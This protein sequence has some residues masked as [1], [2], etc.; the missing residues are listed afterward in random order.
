METNNPIFLE[1]THITWD[2]PKCNKKDLPEELELQWNSSNWTN[3]EV[4]QWLSEYFNVKV[5]SLNVKKLA[6]KTSSG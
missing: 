6:N 4:S 5:K 1:I 3:T 2:K